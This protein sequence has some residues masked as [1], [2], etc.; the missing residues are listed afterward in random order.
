MLATMS[1]F[2]MNRAEKSLLDFSFK[3]YGNKDWIL[4]NKTWL[5]WILKS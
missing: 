1:K 5:T 4:G 2:I 3:T